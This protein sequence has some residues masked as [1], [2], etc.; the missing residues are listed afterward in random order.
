MRVTRSFWPFPSRTAIS[1]RDKSTSL[2]RRRAHSIR[3]CPD[4]YI[5]DA[6]SQRVPRSRLRTAATSL[7]ESTTGRRKGPLRAD[8]TLQYT[9]ILVEDV[10]VEEQK[11]GEG[12]VL[13]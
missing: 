3:R 4:P 7:L 12:L 10:A 2:T 11:R 9:E 13:G 5:N 1:L 6:M 8:H